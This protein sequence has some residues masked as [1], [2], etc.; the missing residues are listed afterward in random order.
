MTLDKAK[1]IVS[2]KYPDAF[3][4]SFYYE[5]NNEYVVVINDGAG[6]KISDDC[7][8]TDQAWFVAAEMISNE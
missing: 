4:E 1:K 5:Y 6:N 8:T 7:F 2:V 3:A